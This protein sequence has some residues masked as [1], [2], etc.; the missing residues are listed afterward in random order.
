MCLVNSY[1]NSQNFFYV[2]MATSL[3]LRSLLDNDKLT[4]PNFNNWYRKLKTQHSQTKRIKDDQSQAECFYCKKQGHW[5]RNCPQYLTSLDPNRL[6]KRK[7][8]SVAD[9]GIY[10]I[11]PCN[12][13]ICDNSTWVL[14]TGSPFNI[15]NSLQGLQVNERFENSERFLN[16]GDGRSVSVLAL[17]N[18]KLVFNS[19][20]VVLSDCHY[21]PTFLL[22]VISVGLLAM[23]GYEI[24]IKKCSCDII[25]N[26]VT[27][28]NGQLS[29][30][31]YLLS[32]PVNVMY[33]S[34]KRP[35][36]DNVTDVYLWHHR[37]GH[38]NKNRMNR[39]SKEG[40]LNVNDC[41]SLTT[42][43]SCLLGKMTKSP[44]TGKGERASDLLT[45]VHSDVCGP[46]STDARGGYSYFITFTDDLSR[47][48]YVYLMRH[49]SESFEM[50][51]LYRNEVEK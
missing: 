24:S 26:G 44:F 7:G 20:V 37:L 43:E 42:C 40:I 33:T 3:S 13:S 29:N 35:R 6:S 19:H 28:M 15:C 50:F 17:G 2:E 48:G 23:N 14:D 27:V 12:F 21:C 32:Q 38:I 18:L 5:K 25:M 36:I 10:M 51:K 39:L 1:T 41:E 8:Q 4:S 49:K 45:L 47:Y 16:V 22:N 30:G 9:Q 31:I 11:T 46:M 34:S